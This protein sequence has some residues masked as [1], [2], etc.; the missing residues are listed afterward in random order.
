MLED[1]RPKK[2]GQWSMPLP[3]VPLE[4]SQLTTCRHCYWVSG[5]MEMHLEE[6]S[7]SIQCFSEIDMTLK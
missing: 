1:L 5:N 7:T 2:E 4:V 3:E 6:Y